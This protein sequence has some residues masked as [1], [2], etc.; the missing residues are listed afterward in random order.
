[1]SARGTFARYVL[2]LDGGETTGWALYDR[3]ENVMI[4]CEIDE[5][6]ALGT[7][8]EAWM[9][10]AGQRTAIGAERYVITVMSA[11][12]DPTGSAIQVYGITRWA[13]LK[14]GARAFVGG[15]TSSDAL[16]LVTDD[17]LRAVGWYKIG[18][19]HAN[20]AARHVLKYLIDRNALP[21]VLMERLGTLLTQEG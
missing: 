7:K 20:D 11:R 21:K 14:Y 9:S 6:L 16:S 17:K 8:L 19:P 12:K 13:A 5:L 1:M 18:M 15:Q 3:A 2:F 10:S 4:M